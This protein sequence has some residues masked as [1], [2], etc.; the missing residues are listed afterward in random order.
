MFFISHIFSVDEHRSWVIVSDCIFVGLHL[1]ENRTIKLSV[2]QIFHTIL[3]HNET[4]ERLIL[5]IG[6]QFLTQI[7]YK[8]KQN[9]IHLNMNLWSVESAVILVLL[10]SFNFLRV[11][12]MFQLWPPQVSNY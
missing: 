4:T 3:K 11:I 10:K 2:S 1:Y 9:F 5:N 7:V 12:L 6:T 8:N